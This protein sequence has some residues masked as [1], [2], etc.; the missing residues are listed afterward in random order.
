MTCYSIVRVGNGYVVRFGNQDVLQTA[1]R[2]NAEK[3]VSRATQLLSR[4]AKPAVVP[5]TKVEPFDA[6]MSSEVS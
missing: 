5:P 2:R 1:N 4:P 6:E 3:L